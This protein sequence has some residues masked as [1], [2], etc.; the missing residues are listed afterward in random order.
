VGA[1]WVTL[2]WLGVAVEL[3]SCLGV[4]AMRTVYDRLHYTGPAATLGAALIAAA[5]V[6]REGYS[7]SSAKAILL[8]AFLAGVNPL[9][10]HATARAAQ[11]REKRLGRERG[12]R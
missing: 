9:I 8:A 10:V 7:S 6:L 1:L 5:V 12:T 2:L 3:F 11:L 4:V